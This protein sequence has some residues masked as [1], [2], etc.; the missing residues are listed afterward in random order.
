MQTKENY[1]ELLK[2]LTKDHPFW[3]NTDL[4]YEII[5]QVIYVKP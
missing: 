5:L 2:T 1:Q 4:A 3:N